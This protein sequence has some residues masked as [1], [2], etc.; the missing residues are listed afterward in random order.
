M[1]VLFIKGLL[2]AALLITA[3]IWDMKKQI[4]PN[5]IPLLILFVGLICIKPIDAFLGFILTGFPYLL[6]AVCVKRTDGFTIG[7]GDIK[8]MA[9]CGSVLG[10]WGGI[11]QSALSLTLALLV[12]AVV[13]IAGHKSL[14]QVKIPLAPCFCAGGIF[15]YS[16]LFLSTI[17]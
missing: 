6:A 11:L 13:A 15:S 14:K 8:L 9:A 17:I 2:L 3:A 7:G 4:I 16:V 10:V 5:L 1:N 12:G